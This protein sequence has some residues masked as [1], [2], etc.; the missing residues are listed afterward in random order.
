M[1]NSK[2]GFE[3]E[4]DN[5]SCLIPLI[6]AKWKDEDGVWHEAYQLNDEI[7]AYKIED[8]TGSKI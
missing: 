3:V 8:G 2:D 5:Q 7:I 1:K 6:H 4:I